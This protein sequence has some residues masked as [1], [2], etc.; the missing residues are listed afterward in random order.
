[1]CV[2]FSNVNGTRYGEHDYVPANV[3]RSQVARTYSRVRGASL[4]FFL[5]S[6]KEKCFNVERDGKGA[7]VSLGFVENT[8]GQGSFKRCAI[9]TFG[10]SFTV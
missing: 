8:A 5:S 9:C 4:L 2:T 10:S 1:M 3:V 6:C 7:V